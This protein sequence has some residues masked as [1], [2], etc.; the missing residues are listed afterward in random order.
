VRG[1]ICRGLRLE[2]VAGLGMA[3]ALPVLPVA[4]WG[5]ESLST[6]TALTVA[7]RDQGGRT[8]ASVTVT[9]T[10]DDGQPASGSVTIKDGSRQVGGVALD[11]KGQATTVL[12]LA[13]GTHALTAVYSGD[14]THQTSI[15]QKA[16]VQAQTSSTPNFAL[17]LTAVS[18]ASLP[19]TL[20]AGNAGTVKVTVT[21]QNNA[22]LTA[23]MF[24]TLSCSGLPNE[25]SC[26]F[27]PTTVEILSTT[28]TSCAT[29]AAAS[30]CPPTTSMVLQTYAAG[31]A[32]ATIP[33]K[34]ASPI[35]WAF[36]LPGALGLGGLAWGTRRRR[37]LNRIALVMLVGLV[38][39]MGTT[40]CSPQYGYYNHGPDPNL[41][42]PAG[43]YTVT[44]TGQTSGVVSAIEN[45]TTMA[46]T[47]Q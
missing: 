37:W 34:G 9:V 13:G 22:S 4:A 41:Q 11:S 39:M 10:G 19:M 16:E 14:T 29:G 31:T 6:E 15:S 5:A 45:S 12:S 7:I 23:P 46:L 17:T 40:A 2:L 42:T 8:K 36:L 26:S 43:T 35:A 32:K 24:V 20:T 28:P 1:M 33:G 44:V 47:V 38:T 18:P 27:S 25:S 30:A 21:P 3:L